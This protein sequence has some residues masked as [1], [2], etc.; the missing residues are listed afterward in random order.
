MEVGTQT[1]L[2][3]RSEVGTQTEPNVKPELDEETFK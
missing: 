3:K 2:I 1:E